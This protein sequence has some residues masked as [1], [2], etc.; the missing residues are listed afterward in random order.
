[1]RDVV[2]GIVGALLGGW[3]LTPIARRGDD[4]SGRLQF[5]EPGGF[6]VGCDGASGDRKARAA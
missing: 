2:I 5:G 6:A 4:Q 3:F 1:M